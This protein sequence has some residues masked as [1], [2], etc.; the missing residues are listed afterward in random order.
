MRPN[1]IILLVVG[2]YKNT[3]CWVRKLTWWH[4]HQRNQNWFNI[5]MTTMDW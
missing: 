3:F 1:S 4:Y 2:L 5:L